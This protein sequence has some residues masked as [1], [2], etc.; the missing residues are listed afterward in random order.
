MV[1]VAPNPNWP[2]RLLVI[3]KPQWA[4][5]QSVGC[6]ALWLPAEKSWLTGTGVQEGLRLNGPG[7]LLPLPPPPSLKTRSLL[8]ALT[9]DP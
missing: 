1:S 4:N 3:A 6:P 2:Q 9:C 5:K 8:P 7:I